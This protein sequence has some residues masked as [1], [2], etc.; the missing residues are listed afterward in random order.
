MI[1]TYEDITKRLGAPLWYD[2]QGV[3]RY[4]AFEPRMCGIYAAAIAFL[5]IQCQTC[6]ARFKVASEW[7]LLDGARLREPRVVPKVPH[8]LSE[9]T[10][11]WDA[12][13]DFHYGDPPQ[14]DGCPAG[15]TMN[16]VPIRVIEYWERRDFDWTRRAE[17]EVAM[18]TLDGA[19]LGLL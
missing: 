17:C 11:P 5:E 12:I 10:D 3:P 6:E 14:H 13:G 9:D 16:S 18:P 4:D 1:R 8:A 15:G 2:D 7:T 19:E